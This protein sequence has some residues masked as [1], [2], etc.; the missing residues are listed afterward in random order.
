[1]NLAYFD[2]QDLLLALLTDALPGVRVD[3]SPTNIE[4]EHV[5]IAGETPNPIQRD[6]LLSGVVAAEETWN[7]TVY[8]LT[9]RADPDFTVVRDRLRSLV[10][11]VTTAIGTDPTLGGAV[12]LM[13]ITTAQPAETIK[14]EVTRQ[15]MMSLNVRC[16]A[17]VTV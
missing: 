5:W 17:H 4:P 6:Y 8:V 2:T 11:A 3:I 7:Y 12:M 16:T 15:M 14:D 10:D 9:E 1:M 13:V